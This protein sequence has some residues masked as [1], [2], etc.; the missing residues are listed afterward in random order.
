MGAAVVT[1]EVSVFTCDVAA[2]DAEADAWASTETWMVTVAVVP[3]FR[4]PRSV[5]TFCPSDVVPRGPAA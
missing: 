2:A 4:S 1:S 3:A 5:V